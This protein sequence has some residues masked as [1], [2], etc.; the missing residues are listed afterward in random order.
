MA[1]CEINVVCKGVMREKVW[2][3]ISVANPEW[4]RPSVK[5]RHRW[6]NNVSVNITDVLR[7]GVGSG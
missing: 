1:G 6:K 3:K 2:E 5:L 7:E 4:T